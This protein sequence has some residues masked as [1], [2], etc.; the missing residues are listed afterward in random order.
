MLDLKVSPE[1]ARDLLRQVAPA[2]LRL[3]LDCLDSREPRDRAAVF[4]KAAREGWDAP[5]KYLE[6]RE[7]LHKSAQRTPSVR[8]AHEAAR[9]ARKASEREAQAQADSE[10][11]ALDAMWKSLDAA[12]RGRIEADAR[13]RLGVLG[14][15]GRASA[16]QDAM[17]RTLLRERLAQ[18]KS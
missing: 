18:A 17:R 13:E 9:T 12:T 4:V 1:V 3:Q 5:A 6:R 15:S 8:E 2:S 16:A 10:T 14:R 7:R 11:Q